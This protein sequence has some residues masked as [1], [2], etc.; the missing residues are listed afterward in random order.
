MSSS[1]EKAKLSQSLKPGRESAQDY[2]CSFTWVDRND[3][4][5]LSIKPAFLKSSLVLKDQKA[6][7]TTGELYRGD[8]AQLM[9]ALLPTLKGKIDLIYIDPPFRTG[10]DFSTSEKLKKGTQSNNQSKVVAYSD[11]F[12]QGQQ[13]YWQFMWERLQL[14]YELLSSKGSLYLHCDYR[15]SAPLK[16][17]LCELFG[18]E[19]YINEIIWSYRT[20]GN[21]KDIGFARKHDTI[22]F[23][24]KNKGKSRWNALKDKSYLSHKY[25]FKNVTLREDE[26]GIYNLVTM[27]DVWDIP[28]LRGNQPERENYPTQKPEALLERIISASTKPGDLVADFFC[29]S[30]TTGVV[31]KK[32]GRKWLMTD[33]SSI[34]IEVSSSR[35]KNP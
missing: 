14:M 19:N 24:T 16:M 21:C 33:R 27:R 11:K 6:K 22:H 5:S 28:A 20:G 12:L 10:R 29:G 23:V 2:D 18:A 8:N 3:E 7:V 25:G 13:T 32:L 17:M 9:K 15:T 34:A 1:T 35:I 30:G 26:H 4:S 31:A